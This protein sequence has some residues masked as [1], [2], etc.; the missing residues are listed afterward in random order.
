MFLLLLTLLLGLGIYAMKLLDRRQQAVRPHIVRPDPLAY[1]KPP[2]AADPTGRLLEGPSGWKRLGRPVRSEPLR[3]LPAGLPLKK[4]AMELNKYQ[5]S[6]Y[7]VVAG[8]R[9]PTPRWKEQYGVWRFEDE[10]MEQVAEF[11]RK[12]AEAAGFELF[13]EPLE[14]PDLLIRNYTRDGANLMVRTRRQGGKVFLVLQY[15][16]NI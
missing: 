8:Q 11:Y 5:R 2:K 15:R 14:K 6:V 9:E 12:A 16:Y 3:G 4:G 13:G 10:P 7:G 1:R